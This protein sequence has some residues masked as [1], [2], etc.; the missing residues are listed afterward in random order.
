LGFK[1]RREDN[2][3]RG[4]KEM[5]CDDL[6]GFVWLRIGRSGWQ[7]LVNA[8]MNLRIPKKEGNF[9]TIWANISFSRRNL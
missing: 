9:L 4:L 1:Q 8:V 2:I 6:T 5:W 7:D 3:K